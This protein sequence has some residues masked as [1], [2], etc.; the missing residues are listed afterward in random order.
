MLLFH[1]HFPSTVIVCYNGSSVTF[2]YSDLLQVSYLSNMKNTKLTTVSYDL[3]TD[4]Y[5]GGKK[6]L[7]REEAIENCVRIRK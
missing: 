6:L 2:F 7:L 1:W 4:A 3:K 5:C